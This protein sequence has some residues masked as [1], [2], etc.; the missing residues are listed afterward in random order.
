[1]ERTVSLQ[2]ALERLM[3]LNGMKKL[4]FPRKETH[5]SL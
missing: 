1:M 2:Q 4:Y 3:S 5:L